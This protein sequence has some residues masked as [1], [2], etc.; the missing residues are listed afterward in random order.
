AQIHPRRA[1]RRRHGVVRGVCLASNSRTAPSCFQRRPTIET[2]RG[3]SSIASSRE[4]R[5]IRSPEPAG[6]PRGRGYRYVNKDGLSEL[7]KIVLGGSASISGQYKIRVK[8]RDG[9]FAGNPNAL[10]VSAALTF[11]PPFTGTDDCGEWRF[12]TV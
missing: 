11:A 8:G 6:A 7:T 1:R 9:T 4:A 12:N 10:P 3:R 2:G 5:A